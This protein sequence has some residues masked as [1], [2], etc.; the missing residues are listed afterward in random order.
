MNYCA[1]FDSPKGEYDWYGEEIT[2]K[3]AVFYSARPI[4]KKKK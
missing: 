1:V 4:D 3:Y 2:P